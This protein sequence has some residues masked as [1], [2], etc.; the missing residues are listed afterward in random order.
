MG[1]QILAESEASLRQRSQA[2]LENFSGTLDQRMQESVRGV[3]ENLLQALAT[4]LGGRQ[5]QMLEQVQDHISKQLPIVFSRLQ[6]Y[7]Q[8]YSQQMIAASVDAATRNLQNTAAGPSHQTAPA[9][10]DQARQ[11]VSD[12]EAQIDSHA[13]AVLAELESRLEQRLSVVAQSMQERLSQELIGQIANRQMEKFV[14]QIDVAVEQGLAS[15]RG[16]LSRMVREIAQDLAAT[17]PSS[18]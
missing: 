3:R 2:A 9:F 6:E 10:A 7:C 8:N 15:A 14:R 5:N 13:A 4:E 1:R 18:K 11:I 17:I 12:S 16:G